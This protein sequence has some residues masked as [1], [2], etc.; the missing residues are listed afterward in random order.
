MAKKITTEKQK[1]VKT[2]LKTV[3]GG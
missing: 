1:K 3:E 2:V